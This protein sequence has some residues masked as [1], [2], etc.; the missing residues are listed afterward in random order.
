MEE[1]RLNKIL[2]IIEG[3]PNRIRESYFKNNHI[4]TYNSIINFTLNI[5]DLPFIQ[6]LWHWVENKPYYFTCGCGNKT[7]FNKNWRNG[8][9]NFCSQKCS[10][11]DKL[12]QEKRKT[13]TLQKWGV[14]NVSKSD[15]VK[16]KQKET[17][18]KK[19][20]HKSSFQN[21]EV[22]KKYK[23]T[24]LEKW[25]VD[26]FFKTD[27]F[28]LKTK[29]YYLEKWGVDHQLKIE[30]VKE[31]IKETCQIKYGVETY[32]NTKHSRESIKNYNRSKYEDEISEFL[33]KN[34]IKHNI[35]ERNII[36]PLILDIFVP[37]FNLAIEFNGLYWHS[38]FK[39]EKDYHLNKTR[40][41]NQKGIHLLHV[42]EDD[43]K[44]RKE[45][46]KSI[47]LNK[48]NL[49]EKKIYSRKCNIEEITNREIVSNFLNKNHIQGYSNYSSA[50]GLIHN[51]DL[52]SIMT[53]GFRWINGKK[54]YELLR[55]CNKLNTQV[56]GSASKLFLHFTKYNLY[57]E[58]IKTY[59]DLSLFSGSV[60][61]NMG[62][63]FDRNSGVNYWWVVD[64]LRK[65]R[66]G[67]NKKKL[68]SMGFDPSLTEV[69][70]MHSQNYYRIWGCGQDRWIWNRNIYI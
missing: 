49:S 62:F 51:D 6:K 29:K 10:S 17:N 13:T 61:H 50:V 59:T 36:N 66:F 7:T 3:S 55:F 69:Q 28:K 45:V 60:Y 4:D 8:Y 41:C 54:E 70:I 63:K 43:W 48:C 33:T 46:I 47:I 39:K 30:E 5:S 9:R 24:S 21:P 11:S 15:L 26:H 14:D 32:L 22:Q 58:K 67:Y 37:D 44:N 18:L 27:E 25:G 20:G 64:G 38:E 35:S 68:V 56:I 53:F 65:H 52:V 31:K 42:W 34:N 2:K 40:L 19:W 23:E 12:T 57:I 16:N 1:N